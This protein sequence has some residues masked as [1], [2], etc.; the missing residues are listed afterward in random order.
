MPHRATGT[1]LTA[2]I[3]TTTPSNMAVTAML[4]TRV[5][6]DLHALGAGQATRAMA[7]TTT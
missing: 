5:I 1:H 4:A 3:M 6:P 2:A 7:P